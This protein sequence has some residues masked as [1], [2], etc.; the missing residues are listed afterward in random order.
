MGLLSAIF[1]P[2]HNEDD[3]S[4][5]NNT[6]DASDYTSV[7]IPTRT[8]SGRLKDITYEIP[9]EQVKEV[10]RKNPGSEVVNR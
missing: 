7:K 6:I 5:S 3:D 8:P 4:G 2:W 9:N 10:L 1:N